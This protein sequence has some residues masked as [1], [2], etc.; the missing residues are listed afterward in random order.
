MLPFVIWLGLLAAA[1]LCF[2]R[3]PPV[4]GLLFIALGVWSAILRFTTLGSPHPVS[5]GVALGSG[6][7]W[8][9]IGISILVRFRD[10]EARS[11]HVALDL[12]RR[13]QE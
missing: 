12:R 6:A 13:A 5:L 8:F 1:G 7:F 9:S 2:P 11:A 3:R 4:S 10:P